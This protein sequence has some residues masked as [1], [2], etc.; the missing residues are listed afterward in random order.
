MSVRTLD[1]R[2]FPNW[3]EGSAAE[4]ASVISSSSEIRRLRPINV[5]L[6]VSYLFKVCN[7]LQMLSLPFCMVKV[8][9]WGTQKAEYKFAHLVVDCLFLCSFHEVKA[10]EL[11]L[12]LQASST[13][14]PTSPRSTFRLVVIAPVSWFQP[15][16]TY[17]QRDPD[18]SLHDT[19][20]SPFFVQ[21]TTPTP[22][23]EKHSKLSNKFS[24][25]ENETTEYS[26]ERTREQED[27][28]QRFVAKFGDVAENRPVKKFKANDF[29]ANGVTQPDTQVLKHKVKT[30]YTPLEIQVVEL[31]E[32]YPGVLLVI[33]VGYKY[34]FFG[35]DAK[36]LM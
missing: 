26:S 23:P 9:K 34:K 36:V 20:A 30:N 27:L 15:Y 21:E 33:E 4:G 28:H 6:A 13:V 31:K 17:F 7:S 10:D 24:Y 11:K 18:S 25:S 14:L 5:S 22:T 3:N 19:P 12:I 16:F 35:E 1:W 32:K 2:V 8:V 29:T